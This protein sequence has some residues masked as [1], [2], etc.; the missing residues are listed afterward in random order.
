CMQQHE[1]WLYV[2]TFDSSVF[3]PYSDTKR[4]TPTERSLLERVGAEQVVKTMGGFDLWRTPDGVRWFPVTRKG[5]G[6]PY[7]YGARNLLSP[8]LGLFVGTAN[9]FGPQVAVRTFAGHWGYV[10]N[11]RGGLEVWL[12]IAGRQN[13]RGIV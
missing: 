7:N 4:R 11:P 5:F 2:G 8:P 6:N 12:G 10:D 9:P 13:G 1:R 3:A